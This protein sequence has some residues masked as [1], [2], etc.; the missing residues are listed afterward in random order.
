MKT[1]IRYPMRARMYGGVRGRK[2]KIGRKLSFSSYSI[3]AFL[4][5]YSPLNSIISAHLVF[6]TE[7]KI[8]TGICRQNKVELLFAK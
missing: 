1:I 6:V 5:V 7:A 4:I 2:T 3:I 8:F